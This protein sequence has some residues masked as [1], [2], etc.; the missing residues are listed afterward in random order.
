VEYIKIKKEVIAMIKICCIT[1]K[2]LDDLVRQAIAKI[3][4]EEIELSV[5]EG[6]RGE[7]LDGVQKEIAEGAEVLLAGGANAKIAERHFHIPV[8]NYKITDF[9][10]LSAI[11][12]GFELGEKVAIITFQSGIS[13]MLKNYLTR[14]KLN[15]QN[16]IYEDSEE[17]EAKIRQSDV[18]VVIGAAHAIEVGQKC[19]K[20]TVSIYPGIE[21]IIE[22][23][24]DGKLMAREIRKIKEQNQYARTILRYTT[25]G[26]FLIDADYKIIDYNIAIEEFFGVDSRYL[27][28]KTIDTILENWC[29]G[30]FLTGSSKEQNY[31]LD[32]NGQEIMEK[33]I[34]T[35]ANPYLFEGAVI[36]LLKL[37]EVTKARLEHARKK[38]DSIKQKGFAVKKDFS[39]IMGN[40]Y[41]I[42]SCV[43]SARVF[44]KSDAS[45]LIY[46]ETG[47]GKELFAQG[48]HQESKRA[49]GPFIA[50]NCGALTETLLEAELFGYDEGAFTGSRR[51]GK[52]GLFELAESGTIF[53][54]EIGEISPLMQ[55]KL[56]R[57]LQE[58]EIMRVGGERIIPVDVRI[59]AATNRDLKHMTNDY[60]R[61]DL[62]YRLSVLELRIPPLREREKD[63][64]YLFEYFYKQRIEVKLSGIP[65]PKAAV[66]L[67][68]LHEWPGNIR[69]MQ[70]ICERFCIY[71][72]QAVKLNQDKMFQYMV[73]AFGEEIVTE[74]ILRK[75]R[76]DGKNISPKLVSE[77]KHTF[78]FNRTKIAQVLGTSRTSI[79]RAMKEDENVSKEAENE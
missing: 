36:I 10:Y 71:L 67:I 66:E 46:G 30:S 20:K 55:T 79:W 6:L 3:V 54:D 18:D 14:Q 56:L 2:Y 78:S 69:E 37:N 4:D 63:M 15:F 21:S 41:V 34:K 74:I 75:H 42:K 72:E 26:V 44:A 57:V 8:L 1:Y 45:V 76:Y 9:D 47:V 16:I 12:D 38:Q 70:N 22:T 49:E 64:V 25:N 68:Q 62:L 48:I 58:H 59:I 17:L 28:N 24:H 53:L 60:F 5:V 65:L 7:I 29:D 33:V 11:H 61:R 50:V 40:S 27:R 35:G 31:I 52:K 51:G 32:I 43:E 73:M 39:D 77:L 13:D 19:K 23:I